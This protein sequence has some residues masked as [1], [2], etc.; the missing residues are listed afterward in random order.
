[1][2]FAGEHGLIDPSCTER[3]CL[4]NNSSNKDIQ[5]KRVQYMVIV[6]HVRSNANPKFSIN[7]DTKRSF[8]PRSLAQ[9]CVTE[10]HKQ[11]FLSKIRETLSDAV[12]N[13]THAPTPFEDLPAPLCDLAVD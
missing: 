12:I 5:P 2:E 11:C 6:E 4:W 8:Y 7:N 1:M 10:D 13:I 9:R 3:A